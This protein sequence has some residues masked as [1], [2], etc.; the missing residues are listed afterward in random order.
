MKYTTKQIES[1]LESWRDNCLDEEDIAIISILLDSYKDFPN[2]FSI[3][4][5]K[6]IKSVI[7]DFGSS[8]RITMGNS[9]RL[10]V[11]IEKKLRGNKTIFEEN[12][13]YIK[14]MINRPYRRN[15]SGDPLKPAK[16]SV[17]E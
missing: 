14:Q 17:E 9:E 11:E 15:P 5:I 4:R 6:N 2:R 10:A 7:D 1:A 8:K 13:E 12:R 3:N 16:A